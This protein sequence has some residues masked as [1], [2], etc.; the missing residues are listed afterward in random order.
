MNKPNVERMDSTFMIA[1]GDK[2]GLPQAT[3][4]DEPYDS[5]SFVPTLLVLT[6]NLRDD[7]SPVPV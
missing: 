7:S 6:G 3:V 2:T 5:L 1:E 4:V